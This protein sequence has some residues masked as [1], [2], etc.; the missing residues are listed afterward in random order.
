[1]FICVV[2]PGA[3]QGGRRSARVQAMLA[4][5]YQSHDREVLEGCSG[6]NIARADVHMRVPSFHGEETLLAE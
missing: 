6:S 3:Y 1:M 5:P 4:A 2:S